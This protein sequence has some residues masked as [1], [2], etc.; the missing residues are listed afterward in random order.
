MALGLEASRPYWSM[1]FHYIQWWCY[2]IVKKMY[3]FTMYIG[4]ERHGGLNSHV[5]DNM[6]S[7]S[8][9][10]RKSIFFLQ[11]SYA[12]VSDLTTFLHWLTLIPCQKRK[13]VHVRACVDDKARIDLGKC[14]SVVHSTI[15]LFWKINLNQ[16]RQRPRNLIGYGCWVWLRSHTRMKKGKNYSHGSYWGRT[17]L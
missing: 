10:R 2:T 4:I 16:R 9:H 14:Y 1:V 15:N 5:R 13:K 11:S 6:D 3:I 12:D 17:Q 7:Q 8:I